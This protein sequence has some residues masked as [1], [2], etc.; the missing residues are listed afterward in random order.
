MSHSDWEICGEAVDG[1]GAIEKNRQLSPE[2]I[3]MDLSM[4]RMNGLEAAVKILQEFPNRRIVLL[5]LYASH[6]LADQAHEAGIRG[7][8][9]KAAALDHIEEGI[10]AVL[11]GE[12]FVSI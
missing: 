12:E 11:R 5:T 9:S 7:T 8:L 2:L 3:V 4:P 6:Q 10:E 1:Y